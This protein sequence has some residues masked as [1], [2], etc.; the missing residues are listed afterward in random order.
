M[1]QPYP[2]L[3]CEFTL[4]DNKVTKISM[5]LETF[6][7]FPAMEQNIKLHM[8]EKTKRQGKK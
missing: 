1:A 8:T 3:S 7:Q 2:Q 5:I 6:T 4:E